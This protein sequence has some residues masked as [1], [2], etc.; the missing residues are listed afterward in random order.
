MTLTVQA[1]ADRSQ[2]DR[3]A[4]RESD[5]ARTPSVGD[6]CYKGLFSAI[7]LVKGKASPGAAGAV[8]DGSARLAARK[9]S[10]LPASSGSESL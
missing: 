5:E 10:L 3:H 8:P 7:E 4:L 6:V 2:P 9:T 1:L